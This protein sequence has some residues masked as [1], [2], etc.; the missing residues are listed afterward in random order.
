MPTVPSSISLTNIADGSAVNASPLR[1]NYS[2]I[3]TAVNALID[4]LGDVTTKGD[5]LAA[6]AADTLA[7]L[8][9]GTNG[10]VLT[11]DSAEPLGM[12]WASIGSQA[13]LDYVQ[14]TS[15]VTVT[16]SAY[17]SPTNVI[18]GTTQAYVASPTLIEFFAPRIERTTGSTIV[19][20]LYDGTTH[21]CN[22]A[23]YSDGNAGHGVPCYA[24]Y[25]FTPTA[26]S[27]TF[28]I[29]AYGSGGNTKVFAGN[30]GGSDAYAPAFLRVTLDA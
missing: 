14:I 13:P 28:N 15:D 30:A 29:K 27:H 16:G 5:L 6:S 3:Q 9:V 25:R 18:T 26:A 21:I 22:L 8:A 17:G 1:N 2:A 4:A 24:A 10:Y 7:R 23:N 20:G 11:A 12:K 19:I